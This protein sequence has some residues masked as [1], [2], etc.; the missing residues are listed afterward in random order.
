MGNL[1]ATQ[2]LVELA[3]ILVAMRAA[4][5][6]LAMQNI[7]ACASLANA[8]QE[9]FAHQHPS[10]ARQSAHASSQDAIS[11]AGRQ[12]AI[13]ASANASGA[14]V[15]QLLLPHSWLNHV[16]HLMHL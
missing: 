9:V 14:S 1:C 7:N 6:L 12:G 15:M 4:A 13:M 5:I 16:H 8:R 11:H 2:I 3:H 10:A